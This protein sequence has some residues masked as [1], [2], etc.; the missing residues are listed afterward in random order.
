MNSQNENYGTGWTYGTKNILQVEQI[1]RK[2][3]YRLHR[4]YEIY[5]IELTVRKEAVL[6]S[7]KNEMYDI[8]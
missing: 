7:E 5:F 3:C 1:E 6:L 8:E 4:W 2:L